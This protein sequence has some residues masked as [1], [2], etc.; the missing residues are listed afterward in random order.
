MNDIHHFKA[1]R[2]PSKASDLSLL[3]FETSLPGLETIYG[4]AHL[5]STEEWDVP[6]PT[7]YWGLRYKCGLEVVLEYHLSKNYVNVCAD[8][9]EIDHILKHLQYPSQ[10]MWRIANDDELLVRRYPKQNTTWILWRQ[11]DN[12]HKEIFKKYSWERE[13]YCQLC[14]FENLHHKQTYWIENQTAG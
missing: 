8:L 5:D 6:G 4:I 9:P 12:G 10:T 3:S 11:D 7:L 1:I 2:F 13:A 14:D